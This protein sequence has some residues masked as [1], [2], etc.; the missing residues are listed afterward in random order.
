[1]ATI[2]RK[3]V[4][5]MSKKMS[6]AVAIS[7]V[8]AGHEITDEIRE[9][10]EALKVSCEKRASHKVVGPT[11]T[12]RE[13]AELATKIAEAMLPNVSYGTADIAGL[14]PELAGATPQ[15]V[16]PLMRALVEAGKVATTKVKGKNTYALA[17]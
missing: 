2:A 7:E 6:Y 11:K 17:E 4:R 1:M 16:S 12:Q 15:K 13:N 8:L 14:I 5:I 10:L 9:R 3:V